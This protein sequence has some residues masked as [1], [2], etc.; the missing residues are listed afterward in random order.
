[1]RLLIGGNETIFLSEENSKEIL[2]GDL[3]VEVLQN[4]LII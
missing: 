4:C 3:N 2:F 1:M